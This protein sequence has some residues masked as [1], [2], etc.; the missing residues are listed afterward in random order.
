MIDESE[1]S[2]DKQLDKIAAQLLMSEAQEVEERAKVEG[3]S[4]YL[5]YIKY[6]TKR[7]TGSGPRFL[8]N[9]VKRTVAF[10]NLINKSL[11]SFTQ[12]PTPLQRSKHYSRHYSKDPSSTHRNPL[13]SFSTDNNKDSKTDTNIE[14][15]T[16]KKKEKDP[17]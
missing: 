11:N 5:N 3:I 17:T 12:T 7:K 14:S 16:D 10:N 8:H 15:N 1:K 6:S 9:A 4:S 2:K 13:S